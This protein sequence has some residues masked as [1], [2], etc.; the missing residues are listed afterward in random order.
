[1]TTVVIFDLDDTLINI[2]VKVPRQTYH[3]L[4][5]FLKEGVQIGIISFNPMISWA[6]ARTGLKKYTKHIYYGDLDRD[7]LFERCLSAISEGKV[8]QSVYYADDRLDNLETVKNR[9]N[10]VKTFHC[11]D[12]YSLYTI[13]HLVLT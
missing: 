12:I 1:M 10:N 9:F 6:C 4:N 2:N 8:A 11:T 13:K 7:V 3:M 5:R